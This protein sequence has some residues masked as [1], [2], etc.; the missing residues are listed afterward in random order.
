MGIKEKILE[1]LKSGE[2]VSGGQ[3]ARELGIPVEKVNVF[4]EGVRLID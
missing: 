2:T 3:L 1:L 4:V